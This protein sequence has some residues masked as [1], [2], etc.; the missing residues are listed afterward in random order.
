MT[1]RVC[2][3]EG[4]DSPQHARELCRRHYLRAW[5]TAKRRAAGIPPRTRREKAPRAV[6]GPKAPRFCSVAGCGRKHKALSLCTFHYARA[7]RGV[8]LHPDRVYGQT[9]SAPGC[10][11]P[12]RALGLCTRHYFRAK[13][14]AAAKTLRPQTLECPELAKAPGTLCLLPTNPDQEAVGPDDSLTECA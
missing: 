8:A 10:G 2:S 4:C 1:P 14:R 7:W 6:R 3:T 12:H 9:C 5:A 13:R 11:K